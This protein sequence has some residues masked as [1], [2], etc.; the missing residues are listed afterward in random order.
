MNWRNQVIIITGSSM[1]I[2]YQLARLACRQGAHVVMNARNEAKLARSC[3]SLQAEGF[4]AL[5]VPGDISDPETCRALV[6]RTLNH[7]GR[8][9]TVIHNAGVATQGTVEATDV[10]VS[11]TVMATNFS[12]PVYLSKYVIPSLKQSRGN[13]LFVSSVAGLHGLGGYSAYC[14]SKMALTALAE[15]LRAELKPFGI[16]TGIAYVGFT[17]NEADKTMIGSHGETVPQP[18]RKQRQDKREIVAAR[19]LNMIGKRT[20]KRVFTP[21]GRLTAF[22]NRLSPSLVQHIVNRAFKPQ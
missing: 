2:G 21:L 4:D 18:S 5:A 6:T 9:D 10:S 22:M 1:G 20:F 16:Y 8:I 11:R 17:E 15:S 3:A 12:G 7:F 19:L 14:A 13:L